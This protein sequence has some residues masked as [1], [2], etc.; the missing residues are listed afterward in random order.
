V[1]VLLLPALLLLSAVDADAFAFS[2]LTPPP[3]VT[4]TRG[5][6]DNHRNGRGGRICRRGRAFVLSAAAAKDDKDGPTQMKRSEFVG[7]LAENKSWTKKQA[8]Q[9]VQAVLS[10]IQ[11]CVN[12]GYKINF[13][14]FGTFAPK[15]R[16]ARKGR[17]PQ[18]GEELQ[19][20]ETVMP[21]FTISKAWKDELKAKANK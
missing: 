13:A 2:S 21:S 17:N 18:T 16:P 9:N 20:A 1:T 12:D 7:V 11:Q 8:E 15:V 10:A 19:I 4:A 5:E 14:G 3:P 6:A